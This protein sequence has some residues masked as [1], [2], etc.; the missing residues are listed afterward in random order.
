[1]RRKYWVVVANVVM[2]S[3]LASCRDSIVAPV[4]TPSGAPA[5]MML[6]PANRPSLSLSG[7]APANA[8][9]DFTVPREGGVFFVGNHAV[10]FPANSICDASGG[11]GPGTWDS[12]CTPTRSATRIHAQVSVSSSGTLIEFTPAMR[13]VPARDARGQV[14]LFMFNPKAIGA[15]GDLSRFNILYQTGKGSAAI[16]EAATD[17]TLRTYVDTNSGITARVLKHFSGYIDSVGRS[18]E[19]SGPADLACQ[20]VP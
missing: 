19:P 12:P 8:S 15:T 7:G 11:Y 18:C 13:F 2:L 1:M 3:M 16:D 9:A 5:S 10:V 14:W 6:A 20:P 17:P 4:A